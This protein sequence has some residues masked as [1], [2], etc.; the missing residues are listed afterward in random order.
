MKKYTQKE[1]NTLT[2]L[3]YTKKM[4]FFVDEFVH[5]LYKSKHAMQ[6]KPF[7]LISMTPKMKE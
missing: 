3:Q 2:F 5:F 6:Q 4:S 1:I 7:L